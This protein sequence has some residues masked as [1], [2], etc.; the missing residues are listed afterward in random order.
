M[1]LLQCINLS[2]PPVVTCGY[3]WLP[4]AIRGYPWLPVERLVSLRPVR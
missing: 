3:P 1:N 4:V 2:Q